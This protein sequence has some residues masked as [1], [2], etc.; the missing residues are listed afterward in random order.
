M[1]NNEFILPAPPHPLSPAEAEKL[2]G[3]LSGFKGGYDEGYL[4]GR[5][6]ILDGR[7]EETF[8]VR[9]IHVMYVASGKGY[10]YSPLDDAVL[11]ALQKL[12]LQVTITDVRQNLVELAAAQRPDLVLVLDGMDLPLEQIATLRATGIKAAI[13]L[14]DDPY[15]TDFTMKIVSHYDYVFTLER[16]CIDFYRGLGHTE[17]HYLPFAAHR[18][19]YRPTTT[20][21]S[22]QRD[23][24]FIGSAYWNR[25]NF[26]REILPELMNYNTVINGIWWDRLP[27]APLYGDRIEIGKWMSPQE[28]SATYSGSKIVINLHRSHIDEAVNNNTLMIPAVSPNPRTFE[29]AATGTLQLCDARDDLSSFYT[30]D[31]EIV[32]F[33]SPQEMMEK[34]RYYLTHEEERRAIALR[35]FERTLKDHMYIKRLNQLLTVIYG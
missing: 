20:R 22:V 13:W 7:P 15:Y 24:S 33:A 32:T 35:A 21:S 16:N 29:I 25:V 4:R 3:R 23:V 18:E 14:T 1:I 8:P 34:I 11:S 17:V 2:R 26:F 31:E 19:H 5:L 10:P 27:E 12:T 9:K 6:A 30:P 28:T